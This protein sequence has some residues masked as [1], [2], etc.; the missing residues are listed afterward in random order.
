MARMI[1]PY[2]SAEIKSRAEKRVFEFFKNDPAGKDYTVLHSLGLSRHVKRQYG[3][4]DFVIL[5]PGEGIFCLEIKGGRIKREKGVWTF[6]NRYGQA[7]VKAFS[8]FTQAREGMFSLLEAIR[9][10]FGS[11]HRLHNLVFR[12]GVM[13]PDIEFTETD[14]EFERWEIYDLRDRKFPVSDY[15]KRVSR[16]AHR[17]VAGTQWYNPSASRPTEKDIADLVDLLRGDFEKVPP[18]SLALEETEQQLLSLTEEQYEWL[19]ALEKKNDRCLFDGGAGTGKTMIALE[20]ARRE[21]LREKSVGIFCYNKLLG[22]QIGHSIAHF[23]VA[24]GTAHKL[25]R[26]FAVSSVCS[27][28]E[29]ISQEERA[30]PTDLYEEVYP[31]YAAVAA[32]ERLDF[33]PFDTLIIDEAQDLI[34]PANL[35]FFDEIL[36]G[37]LNGG[38]WAMFADFHRQA[39]YSKLSEDQMIDALKQRSPHFTFCGLTRNCRNTK[40]IGEE[41]A[42]V[43]GFTKPPFRPTA[44]DGV[45]VDY[46]FYKTDSDQLKRIETL[47]QKLVADG[48]P[49]REITVLSTRAKEHSCF[50][51]LQSLPSINIEQI[52]ESFFDKKSAGCITFATIHAFK[53]LENSIIVLTDCEDLL[54]DASHSLLYV[55]MSR[56]KQGLHMIL[57]ESLRPQYQALLKERIEKLH[58]GNA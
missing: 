18:P 2:L 3:E 10:R 49:P 11:H 55:G 14:P 5:A 42:S 52:S 26:D 58:S 6:I 51:A 21:A 30:A 23:N 19:D 1:P 13:F 34:T 4:I 43:S 25:M 46:Q 8:P 33:E 28:E 50:S 39:I 12:Y 38:K 7:S 44:I 35:D 36:R 45:P 53:G 47:L 20:F 54:S 29:F 56:A 15:V 9:A 32:R 40:N 41:T 31:F 24:S 22:Q 57:S 37:G 16:G 27:R 17:Q 48:I